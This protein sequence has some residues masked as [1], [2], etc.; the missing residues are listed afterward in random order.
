MKPGDKN[1]FVKHRP[2]FRANDPGKKISPNLVGRVSAAFALAAQLEARTGNRVKARYWLEQ[3]A[4]LYGL[5]KTTAVGELV[6]A[7]PHAYYPEDSW[8]DDMEFGATELALAARALGD[9]REAL[10]LRAATK[11]AK[12]YMHSDHKDTLNLYDVSALAHAELI[13]QLRRHASTTGL[14]ASRADLLAD[15]RR[16][17]D[18]GAAHAGRSRSARR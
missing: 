14:Q 17:L 16:Q 9:R 6:T 4:T 18:F 3:A 5:A 11:W 1:Y 10:W 2:V 7:F 8:Q 15:M 13:P 12:A